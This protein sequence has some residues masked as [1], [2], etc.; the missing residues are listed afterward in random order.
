ML[1]LNGSL[2]T[3]TWADVNMLITYSI[4]GLIIALFLIRSANVLQLGDDAAR[5]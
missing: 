3:K 5:N 4:V 1:W 2:A